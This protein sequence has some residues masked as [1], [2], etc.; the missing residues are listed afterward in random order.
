MTWTFLSLSLTLTLSL[1][2][3][4]DRRFIEQWL[5]SLHTFLKTITL[6]TSDKLNYTT[7]LIALHW[8]WF[9]ICTVHLFNWLRSSACQIGESCT[10]YFDC[11]ALCVFALDSFGL[12]LLLLMFKR[13]RERERE[14][15]RK[16][17]RG[18]E[19]D[20]NSLTHWGWKCKVRVLH[21]AK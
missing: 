14:R 4:L 16:K 15:E 1:S 11:I 19:T 21:L 20:T 3:I 6:Q 18:R 17:E 13:E 7:L 2:S 9:E 8:V 5:C 10:Q 12:L